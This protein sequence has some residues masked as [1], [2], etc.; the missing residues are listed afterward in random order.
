MSPRARDVPAP[1][2]ELDAVLDDAVENLRRQQ[3]P[4]GL[5]RT[6]YLG[7]PLH[8]GSGLV[9]TVLLAPPSRPR[10]E[11]ERQLVESVVASQQPDG[12]FPAYMGGPATRPVARIA[13]LA[14]RTFARAYRPTLPVDAHRALVG[15]AERAR[16]FSESAPA[17]GV[18]GELVANLMWNAVAP[19]APD[20]PGAALSAEAAALLLHG[21]AGELAR[22]RLSSFA[23]QAVPALSVLLDTTA[24][25]SFLERLAARALRLLGI[26]LDMLARRRLERSILALQARTGGW[27]WSVF[28]TALNLLALRALGHDARHPAVRAGLSFIDGLRQSGP[29]GALVQS[30]CNAELWDSAVAGSTL[31]ASGVRPAGLEGLVQ[32]LAAEQQ[33]DGLWAFGEGAL[34]GDNDSSA[35]VLSFLASASAHVSPDVAQRLQAAAARCVDALLSAQQGDGGFGYSPEPYDEP[36]GFGRRLPFGIETALVDAST[37]DVTGRV[38]GALLAA[39]SAFGLDADLRG[40]MEA[41]LGRA[42]EF[43][44]NAQG[45]TGSWPGRWTSGYLSSLAFVLPPLRAFDASQVGRDWVQRARAF[46][47]RHQNADGGWGET[48]AADEH[49]LRAGRGESTPVQ[50]AYALLALVATA[51]ADFRGDAAFFAGIRFLLDKADCG[52]WQNRRALYTVAFREDYFDAPFMTDAMVTAALLYAR[53]ALKTGPDDATR[54]LVCPSPPLSRPGRSRADRPSGEPRRGHRGAAPR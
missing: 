33:R 23:R 13:E 37:A 35:M 17:G 29:D 50:T 28:G 1:P 6:P 3:G 54:E 19:D 38:M 46:V 8:T 27:L 41:A 51:P 36:Y 4:D 30:W 42:V 43:L 32:R 44:R 21:P 52:R 47:F 31:L 11:A 25:R 39:R 40:R 53:A 24:N 9:A 5:W 22:Q 10:F 49:P 7:G 34:E 26:D 16:R 12:G 15:A 14:I 2:P 20:L 45:P 48:T 18:F